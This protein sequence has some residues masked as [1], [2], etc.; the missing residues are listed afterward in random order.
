[1][2]EAR[3]EAVIRRMANRFLWEC[4]NQ[5]REYVARASRSQTVR[6]RVYSV[7]SLA[8]ACSRERVCMCKYRSFAIK[9][10]RCGTHEAAGGRTVAEE[11]REKKKLLQQA[12]ASSRTAV[13][14]S[15]PARLWH[16]TLQRLMAMNTAFEQ[17]RTR[18][19]KRMMMTRLTQVSICSLPAGRGCCHA[20]AFPGAKLHADRRRAR[21]LLARS[22]SIQ[23]AVG[24]AVVELAH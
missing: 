22:C 9:F 23:P 12:R 10:Q 4:W 8:C 11:V 3:K 21:C 5:W 24:N 7:L 17:R 16:I 2:L 19:L 20:R 18:T 15:P 14:W 6:A 13:A 1:M